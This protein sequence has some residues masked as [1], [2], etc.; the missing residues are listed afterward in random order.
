[1]K[2][3]KGLGLIGVLLIIGALV[4]TAGGVV[5]WEKKATLI[6]PPTLT[7]PILPTSPSNSAP[8]NPAACEPRRGGCLDIMTYDWYYDAE[9]NEC[10]QPHAQCFGSK[11]TTKEECERNCVQLLPVQPPITPTSLK[12]RIASCESSGGVYKTF[13]HGCADL[14]EYARWNK[15]WGPHCDTALID[16]C[17]CGPDKCWNGAT[18]EPN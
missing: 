2:K 15:D 13:A 16:S 18:C 9:K 10:Y 1:M 14:C 6:P 7:P 11:F 5:V 4:L 8:V 17:D 12:N 3:Q